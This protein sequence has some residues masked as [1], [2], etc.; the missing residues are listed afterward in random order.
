MMWGGWVLWSSSSGGTSESTTSDVSN[1]RVEVL[2][3]IP[4]DT[5]AYT[6]GL[7]WHEG[8]LYE[9][10]GQYGESDLRRVD[11]T[12]GVVERR[13]DLAPSIFGEGLA[14]VGR[15][16]IQLTWKSEIALVY[17]LDTFENQD[18]FSY[19]GEGWGLSF[20]GR[21]LI[22][23]NGSAQLSFRDPQT[24]DET[25]SLRVTLRGLTFRNLNELEWAEDSIYAN[26][27]L[28]DVIVRIDPQSGEITELID[29]ADLLS[30]SESRGVDV[31]NGIAYNPESRTFYI[32]GKWWPK[33]FEVRFVGK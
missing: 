30:P 4:H 32:T 16:L 14:R 24:F 23:S 19:A 25:G 18:E 13:I 33:M 10:T 29:A 7:L 20:D 3:E 5:S 28:Q 12:S 9:S 6:Q 31:L 17:D 21:R 26:V 1:L 8:K 22:M 2:R 27:W 15:R 11:P